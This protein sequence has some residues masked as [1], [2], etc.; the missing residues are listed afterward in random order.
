MKLLD[1]VVIIGSL[2]R[3]SKLHHRC[4][5]YLA[6][7]KKVL[8]NLWLVRASSLLHLGSAWQVQEV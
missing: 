3:T 1:T 2:D 4:M 7:K 8:F 6:C 5:E